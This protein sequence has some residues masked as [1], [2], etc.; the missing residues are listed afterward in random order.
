[1][2]ELPGVTEILLTYLNCPPVPP[3]TGAPEQ[4]TPFLPDDPPP[5]ATDDTDVIPAGVTKV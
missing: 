2:Y 4:P 3:A 5:I 1:V